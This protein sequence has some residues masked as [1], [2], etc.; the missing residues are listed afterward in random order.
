MYIQLAMNINCDYCGKEFEKPTNKVNE[1]I[2]H[3]WKQFCSSECHRNY[4]T[5]KIKCTCANCGKELYKAP[6]QIKNSK[7]G[8][9]FCNKSCACSYNNSHFRTG[10]NNPNFKDGVYKGSHY[11]T[12]AYREYLWKCACCNNEDPDVIQVHHIDGNHFNNSIDNLIPICANCHCKIHKGSLILTEE[13]KNNRNK[14]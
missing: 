14:D 13:H 3:G 1:S 10:E 4:K 9:V 12:I 2:K 5:K 7:S 6:Y 8:N 11:A